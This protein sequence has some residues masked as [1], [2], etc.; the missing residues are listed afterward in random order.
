[1]NNIHNTTPLAQELQQQQQQANKT[2]R[3][4]C[5]GNRKKQRYRRQLYDQGL[6]SQRVD[7]LVEEKFPSQIQQRQLQNNKQST[8]EK[9][10]TQ[11]LQVYIPLDRV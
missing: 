4:K 10:N 9:Y 11:N 7:K 5:R 3:Q 2:Q 6:N 1:M 8:Q